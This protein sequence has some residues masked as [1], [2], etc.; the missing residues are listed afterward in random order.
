MVAVNSAEHI[1]MSHAIKIAQSNDAPIGPNPRVGCVILNSEGEYLAQGY[2]KGRGT[3]HAEIEAI[4]STDLKLMGSTAV[5]T[6]E[7]CLRLDR[8][9][10]CTRELIKAGIKKVIIAQVDVTSQSR[11]GAKYLTEHGIEVIN[12]VMLEEASALNP[13]LTIAMDQ[14]RPYLRLKIAT[15]LDGKV[16]TNSGSSKWITGIESRNLVH[17]L[18]S[19]SHAIITSVKTTLL[20]NSSFTARISD[21]EM[22]LQQPN[23]HLL[24]SESI[25]LDHPIFNA[26]REVS[27]YQ[28]IE[29]DD[30]LQKLWDRQELSVLVEAGPKLSTA[31]IRS[32]LVN[33]LFWFTAPI[34]IGADGLSAID[35]LGVNDIEEALR[36]HLKSHSRIG[37]DFL[38]IYQ[39][40]V[41]A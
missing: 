41:S 27:H 26:K 11:F 17:N 7:P 24:G 33:E 32:G 10:D 14:Q 13:W 22:H 16:A 37:S 40:A 36:P 34:I 35:T 31:F 29:L 38:S 20:D 28:S 6:L 1:A 30:V 21:S 4:Q 2:H 23:L 15:S 39:F 25:P 3:R 19:E 5:L 8:D 18:R 12:E 9:T